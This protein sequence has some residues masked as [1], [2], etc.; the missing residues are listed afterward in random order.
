LSCGQE[1]KGDS[2]EDHDVEDRG[3]MSRERERECDNTHYRIRGKG[4]NQAQRGGMRL[5]IASLGA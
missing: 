5:S 1:R 4:R 2:R 3:I